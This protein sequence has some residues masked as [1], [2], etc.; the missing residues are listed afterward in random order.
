MQKLIFS[1]L[2]LLLIISCSNNSQ[3]VGKINSQWITKDRYSNAIRTNFESFFLSNNRNPSESELKDLKNA[4]WQDL[5]ISTVLFDEFK[6][7]QIQ[8]SSQEV[9]DTLLANIPDIIL[10]SK[11]FKTDGVNFDFEKYHLCL[12]T[13]E[14]INL[15]WL[16]NKYYL[17]VIPMKKLEQKV[18]DSF[19]PSDKDLKAFFKLRNTNINAKV[20]VFNT[21]NSD[22]ITVSQDEVRNYFFQNKQYFYNKPACDL[23]YSVFPLKATRV[24]SI[25]TKTQIDSIYRELKKKGN[26]NIFAKQH[27]DSPKAYAAGML[28]YMTVDSLPPMLKKELQDLNVNDFTRPIFWN[29]HWRIYLLINKTKSMVKLQEIAVKTK[30]S[31]ATKDIYVNKVAEFVKLAREIGFNKAAEEMNLRAISIT[32]LSFTNSTIP[33]FGKSDN[34][35]NKAFQS[36]EGKILDPIYNDKLNAYVIF[37]VDRLVKADLQKIQDVSPQ[38]TDSLRVR[39]KLD[40]EIALADNFY[41]EFNQNPGGG[42]LKYNI[43][44]MAIDS[45]SDAKSL[46]ALKAELITQDKPLCLLKPRIFQNKVITAYLLTNNEIDNIS[47][48]TQKNELTQ[49][50][51]NEHKKE[52]FDKWFER[53]LKQAKIKDNRS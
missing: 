36:Q 21:I 51:K 29:D 45:L 53:K 10:N 28:E 34:I 5:I 9:I 19:L 24:D 15:T 50:Y 7:Y 32:D 48:Q 33:E 35:I 23:T 8:V 39:K 37:K 17:S 3:Y 42:I 4:T 16:R 30:I 25:Y 1:L 44:T 22:K 46:S 40:M 12:T 18:A 11:Q 49:A 38:I 52:I 27:S 6:K 31:R 47:F 13:N 2:L 26:F 14:P 41:K 43:N 20:L